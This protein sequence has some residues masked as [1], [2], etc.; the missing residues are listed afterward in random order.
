MSW[1]G[2]PARCNTRIAARPK[3]TRSRRTLLFL[4]RPDATDQELQKA[5]DVLN[6]AR[7]QWRRERGLPVTAEDY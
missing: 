6:E 1:K 7:R 3:S 4:L 2:R 5:C